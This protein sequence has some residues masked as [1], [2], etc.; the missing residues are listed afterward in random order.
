MDDDTIAATNIS[1]IETL[2]TE[3]KKFADELPYWAKYLAEKILTGSNISASNIDTSYS[4][5]LEE[6]RLIAETTKPEISIKY[7]TANSGNYK[8]DLQLKK[9]DSVLGVNALSENQTI[10]FSPNLTIIYGA[11]GSGKSGYIRLLKKVFYSK[12]S[13][14]ILPNIHLQTGHKPI[15]ANFSFASSNSEFSLLYPV[16]EGN[17]EFEQYAVF[18]GKSVL[19]HLDQKNEFEFRPAGLS[20]FSNFTD[21][22]RDVELKLNADI[23]SRKNTLSINDLSDLFEGDSE[24]K[25]AIQNLNTKSKIDELKKYT[26]FTETDLAEK[27]RIEKEYDDLLLASKGKEKAIKTLGDIKNS[28]QANRTTFEAFNQHLNDTYLDKIRNAIVDCVSKEAIAKVEGIEN[29]NTD[30]IDGIGTNEW[31]NFIVAADI[32]AKEQKEINVMY[33]IDGDNC[34]LCHQ[35]L[36]D[37]AKKLISNYWEF[38]KSVAEDNLKKSQED[39]N[40]LKR[41]FEKLNFDLFPADNT[42]T[43]WLTENHPLLLTELKNKLT[44]QS[45]LAK[46]IIA[47]I[48]SK[49][50]HTRMDMKISLGEYE[51]IESNIDAKIKKLTGDEQ[52]KELEQLFTAKIKLVHKEKFNTHFL[53]FETYV[54]NQ[55]WIASANKANFGK[56]KITTSEKTLS[57]KY[58]NQRYIDIFNGECNGLNGNF[59]VEINHTGSA[60][61]S[62]RQL[63]LK[64]KNPNA[65][66][67]EGEQ[68]VIAL[69]DFLTEM[70]LSEINR[71]IIFD[72]PV[73]SLDEKRKSDI[74]LRFIKE[75]KNKQVIIFTHDLV[76]VSS[77]IGHSKDLKIE[78]DC[79]WIENRDNK[80]GQVWLRNAPSYEKEYRNSDPV[81]E[82]LKDAKDAA[83]PPEKREFLIKSGFTALRTC[84]EVLVI[85]GLFKNVVQ[86]YNERVSVDTLSEVYF[87]KPLVDELQHS[88]SQCCRYMEGHTHSD[89]FAY[90]KPEPE[91][92]DEEI[93]RY[94]S[95]KTRIKQTKAPTA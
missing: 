44:K 46:N 18:D 37:N 42:L 3:V 7:N 82:Y 91:S 90:K 65:V 73:T 17:P 12:A 43:V 67:S 5:L 71:G 57:S 60:G 83:C 51:T 78:H 55:A 25:T 94:D 36:S 8:P 2:D 29:F 38:I 47:D 59:G 87:D 53:K 30:K 88:F 31:K 27:L 56:Q 26:P 72:D 34:L 49:N 6:L 75:A 13:E 16:S 23:T 66:L 24:I 4:Y 33:P 21:A 85:H 64:G 93:K 62:F 19:K 45:A 32:F 89:K 15:N 61:K 35:P 40:K 92:L 95:I 74:A 63:K 81:K 20:F 68:K 69:A 9:L 84:Y 10:E 77:L 70:Q 54:N 86:R 28:L 76:F 22:V 48:E 79:H 39:L 41:Y 58:F 11:N 52:T 14:E 80:P 1:H 50:I